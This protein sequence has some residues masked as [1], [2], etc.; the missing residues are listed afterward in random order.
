M[1]GRKGKG[2]PR[3]R[4]IISIRRGPPKGE[5]SYVKPPDIY[6]EGGYLMEKVA[7]KDNYESV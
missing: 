1:L 2:R 7:F 5:G 3:I 4:C 6:I